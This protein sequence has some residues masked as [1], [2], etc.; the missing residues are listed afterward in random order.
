MEPE[1][2]RRIEDL[3]HQALELDEARRAEFLAR[4]CG[5]DHVLRREVESLLAHEKPAEQFIESPAIEVLGGMV[6][7]DPRVADSDS[8]RI[9]RRVSHYRILEQIGSGG[10]GVVYKAQDDVLHRFV[11]LKFLPDIVARDPLVLER[12]R[13]EARAASALNHPNICTIYEI[14]QHDGH[15]FIVMEF[16]DGVSLKQRISEKP[17]ELATLLSLAIQI[18]DALDAAHTRGIV[19]RDIKPANIFVTKRGDA[20]ILDFGLAKIARTADSLSQIDPDR[21]LTALVEESTATAPGTTFGTIAYMSPEQVRAKELDGR[22]DLFSFGAVLYEMATGVLP[23]PGETSGV[24]FSAI[25]EHPPIP[26]GRINPQMPSRLEAIINKALEKDRERRYQTAPEMR[27]DLERLKREAESGSLGAGPPRRS[28]GTPSSRNRAEKALEVC[29][30]RS[31]CCL[32]RRRSPPLSV[33][34]SCPSPDRQRHHRGR[35]FCKQ[36]RRCRVRRHPKDR[37]RSFPAAIAF[38]ESA[39]RQQGNRHLATNDPPTGHQAH[40]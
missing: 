19:H 2:W 33:A 15:W 17:I 36:H 3:F 12:F 9:G 25:L 38:L 35:R 23:F 5:D 14:A 22:T 32:D 8:K 6:A 39:L 7:R 26:A 20:K 37:A 13:R 40:S 27:T 30:S 1:L 31:S 28:A 4:S 11:A 16:L 21:T 10:M 18:A 34:S 29:R 24:V